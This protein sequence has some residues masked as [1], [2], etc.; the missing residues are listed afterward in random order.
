M[1]ESPVTPERRSQS[2]ELIDRLLTEREQL[3][4][5]YCRVAGLEPYQRREAVQPL[6]ER[7]CQ[8]LV[9]YAAAVHFEIY[10]RLAQGQERRR[11]VVDV[12]EEHYPWI[13]ETTEQVVHFNDLCS[14]QGVVDGLPEEL[15]RL[16]EML[17]TRFEHEDSVFAAL[18]ARN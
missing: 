3:L 12:A 13:A 18:L 14:A 6:L 4:V 5:L 9:D 2:R 11:A 16:G 10:G 1:S 7:F 17:A 15:S 8:V